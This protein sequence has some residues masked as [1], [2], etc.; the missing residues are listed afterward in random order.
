MNAKKLMN[1]KNYFLDFVYSMLLFRIDVNLV[2]LVGIL[3]I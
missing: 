2:Q 3:L 1:I